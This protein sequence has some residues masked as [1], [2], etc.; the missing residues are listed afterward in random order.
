MPKY[1]SKVKKKKGKFVIMDDEIFS[2]GKNIARSKFSLAKSILCSNKIE[3]TTLKEF[4]KIFD[5]ID[6]IAKKF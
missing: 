5:T 4:K 3:D 1:I 6:G 2:N